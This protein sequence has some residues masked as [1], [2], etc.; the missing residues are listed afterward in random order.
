MMGNF[1]KILLVSFLSLFLECNILAP[2][3]TCHRCSYYRFDGIAVHLADYNIV[4]KKRVSENQYLGRKTIYLQK[5]KTYTI[6]FNQCEPAIYDIRCEIFEFQDNKSK[7]PIR[8]FGFACSKQTEAYTTFMI[9]E[10]KQY[11]IQVLANKIVDVKINL[12]LA[13]K[14]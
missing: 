14:N 13:G 3:T 2:S 6:Y 8:L 5:D 9:S 4:V 10:S 11:E 7:E 1:Q 12:G